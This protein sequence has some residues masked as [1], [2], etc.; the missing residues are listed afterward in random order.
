MCF[1]IRVLQ[2]RQQLQTVTSPRN[3]IHFVLKALI[4]IILQ[5]QHRHY[6]VFCT[7]FRLSP[8][9]KM[10]WLPNPAK[11]LIVHAHG[12]K[13]AYLTIAMSHVSHTR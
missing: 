2:R 7:V 11:H 1:D 10:F 3:C 6:Q 4:A 12:Q 9:E 5:A 13:T 8:I